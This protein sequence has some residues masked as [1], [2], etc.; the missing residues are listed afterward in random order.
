ME[1][2]IIRASSWKPLEK[3]LSSSGINN[4]YVS[5]PSLQSYLNELLLKKAKQGEPCI[6]HSLMAKMQN[7]ERR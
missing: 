6:N 3:P 1:I 4:M 7:K 5:Y 2:F